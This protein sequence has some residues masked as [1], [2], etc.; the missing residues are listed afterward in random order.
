MSDKIPSFEEPR[1]KFSCPNLFNSSHTLQ[2]DSDDLSETFMHNLGERCS[3]CQSIN[4]ISN[5]LTDVTDSR[6]FRYPYF[7]LPLFK[8]VVLLC[9]FFAISLT[10]LFQITTNP[11]ILFSNSIDSYNGMNFPFA[12][13][14]RITYFETANPRNSIQL[15]KMT[16]WN[17]SI[18][19]LRSSHLVENNWFT[20]NL[21]L[22]RFPIQR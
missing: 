8:N 7:P 3:D 9:V 22:Q 17:D 18:D 2:S 10:V 15:S 14:P 5:N 19:L 6:E 1:P 16:F 13:L 21:T 20:N 11:H 4:S 12:R